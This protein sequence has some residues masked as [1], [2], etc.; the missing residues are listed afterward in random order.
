MSQPPARIASLD[1]LRGLAILGILAVNVQSFAMPSAARL[2]P[3][4]Q[5]DLDPASWWVWLATYVL[6]DGKFIA[7][8]AMLFG[9]GIVLQARRAEDRGRAPGPLHYRRMAVLLVLGL[10]HAYLVW[11]GD[12]L[13]P[14]AVCGAVAFPYRALS[15]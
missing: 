10:L 2:N 6:A 13:V 3:A 11:Y 4:V 7:V 12:W 1:A 9:A 15:P 8:F 14:L 5:G